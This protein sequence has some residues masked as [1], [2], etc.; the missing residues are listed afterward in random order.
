MDLVL[1]FSPLVNFGQMVKDL[2]SHK[3][4]PFNERIQD[5]Q[6]KQKQLQVIME[7]K[8]AGI[9][10][11]QRLKTLECV[12]SDEEYCSKII[13][14]LSDMMPLWEFGI[15]ESWTEEGDFLLMI[16]PQ[17][18]NGQGFDEVYEMLSDIENTMPEYSLTAFLFLL[19]YDM[20]E[21]FE[22]WQSCIEHFG[23][24]FTEPVGLGPGG[25]FDQ[26]FLKRYLKKQGFPELFPAAELAFFPKPNAFF[27]ASNDDDDLDSA[28]FPFTAQ[29][30]KYLEGQWKAAKVVL[31][32]YMAAVELVAK[33]PEVLA[34][35]FEG[36]RQ[37]YGRE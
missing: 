31:D 17:G 15:E 19:N 3:M 30:I 6:V 12:F 26:V 16:E 8:K 34:P 24:P 14:I 7:A 20:T 28:C 2:R 36:L 35:F 23:W 21:D 10:K 13:E 37:S 9:T 18:F 33:S 25:T 5:L 32:K 27:E 29:H 22:I 4:T 11:D 1:N